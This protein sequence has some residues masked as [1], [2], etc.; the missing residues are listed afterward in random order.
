MA[1]SGASHH[2]DNVE[3]YRSTLQETG[4]FTVKNNNTGERVEA[5]IS[6]NGKSGFH[7]TGKANGGRKRYSRRL[8]SHHSD[9]QIV[10][11]QASGRQPR[12]APFWKAQPIHNI[13]PLQKPHNAGFRP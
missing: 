11:K 3:S 5:T 13:E 9:Q 10:E 12:R 6:M 4:S 8:L 2:W 1:G 7:P